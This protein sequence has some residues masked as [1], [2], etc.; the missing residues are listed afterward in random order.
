M[1]SDFVHHVD[2][3]VKVIGIDHVGTSS[4]FDGDGDDGDGG[5]GGVTGYDCAS[6]SINVMIELVRRGHSEKDIVA[7]RDGNPCG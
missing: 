5:G 2:C 3:A 4:D 1:I 6:E 7:P